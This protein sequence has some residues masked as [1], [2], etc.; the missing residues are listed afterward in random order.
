M[1]AD[2]YSNLCNA[3]CLIPVAAYSKLALFIG[4]D[5]LSPHRVTKGS[6]IVKMV[7]YRLVAQGFFKVTKG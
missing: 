6:A 7:D 1:M 5:S 3:L 2:K 4:T